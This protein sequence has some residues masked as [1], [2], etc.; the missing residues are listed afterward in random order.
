M[1]RHPAIYAA[2]R[3]VAC[4]RMLLARPTGVPDDCF[5]ND[6]SRYTKVHKTGRPRWKDK[7]GNLY[8]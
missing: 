3:L 4:A 7:S 1:E 8:E 6:S 5:L 2:L